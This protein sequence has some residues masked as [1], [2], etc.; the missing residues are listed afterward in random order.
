MHPQLISIAE[1]YEKTTQQIL[2]LYS[3]QKGRMPILKATKPAHLVSNAE[4]RDFTLAGE[5][6]ALLDSW[7]EGPEGAV[8]SCF[9][10]LPGCFL[11]NYCK[12]PWLLASDNQ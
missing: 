3:L 1:K 6:M 5:D 2:I 7:E 9:S 8:R 11:A 12:V 4:V 10:N